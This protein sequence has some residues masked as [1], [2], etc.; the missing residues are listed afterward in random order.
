ML[1][2]IHPFLIAGNRALV[3]FHLKG[4]TGLPQSPPTRI[5]QCILGKNIKSHSRVAL[6]ELLI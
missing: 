5:D 3:V 6:R 1:P 4:G 2:R